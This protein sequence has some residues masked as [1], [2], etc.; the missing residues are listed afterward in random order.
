MQ[1]FLKPNWLVTLTNVSKAQWA[2]TVK[3]VN[4]K[5]AISAAKLKHNGPDNKSMPKLSV[6]SVTPDGR[7]YL[8]RCKA[9]AEHIVELAKNSDAYRYGQM[10]DDVNHPL[11]EIA[12]VTVEARSQRLYFDV[13]ARELGEEL[14]AQLAAKHKASKAG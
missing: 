12:K 13:L 6:V 3:A 5:A 14:N 11:H 7:P 9:V 4:E 8:E 10:L 1:E 2:Y